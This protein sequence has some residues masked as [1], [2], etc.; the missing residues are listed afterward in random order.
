M[1]VLVIPTWY[2]SGKDQLMGI[3]H[4]EFC[5]ALAA[6]KEIDV[7]MLFIERERLNNP[8]KYLFMAKNDVIKEK[9]YKTYIKRM[10]NVEPISYK[11]QLKHYVKVLDQA[12]KKY[13]KNNPKPDIIHAMVTIP[14]GYAACKLG[15]KY[16]IPVIVTE[17]ASYF[18]RF[19]TG[20]YKEYGSYVLNHAKFTTVSKFMAKQMEEYTDHVEVLPNLINTEIFKK[21]RKKIKEL[22]IVTVSALRQGKRI[23]DIIKALKIILETKK[24][25]N[26]KLTIVG[27]GYLEEVYKNK[28]QE[29]GMDSYVDFVGRKSKEEISKIL[30]DHNIFVI[31]SEKE[32]F[33]I[34]G[35]EALAS[36]MPVVSTNCLGPAEYLDEKSGKLVEVGNVKAI[37]D[38]I[39][40]V[41]EN[42]DQYDPKYL[43][44]KANSY[45]G[46]KVSK[47]AIE[48]YKEMLK[49]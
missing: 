3:Y 33:C 34:P 15:E 2:P 27:D 43:R 28:C 45:S 41:Y 1:N 23:D 36:G 20:K 10:L 21:E 42:I 24:E 35:V 25:L 18:K 30:Q 9:G 37:A 11:W 26:P 49:K 5:E 31:A 12:F 47:K 8:I 40:E 32:T 17:H 38:A 44:K 29:L 39:I 6:N 7:N 22:R 19:F 4:K 16:N 46:E 14:A 13:L 48:L